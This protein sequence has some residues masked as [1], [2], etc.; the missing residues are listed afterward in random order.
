MPAAPDALI[1]VSFGGP[2]GPD[3]V[4]P[5]LENVTRGRNVP[6]ERLREVAA[7]Y[8]HFGGV[9]PLHRAVPRAR[10]GRCGRSS[11]G[12]GRTCPSTGATATGTRCSPTRSGADGG[13]RGARAPSPS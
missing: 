10:G 4:L 12:T 5:F 9:S 8:E 13:R 3:D 2:E 1:V 6:Q 7:H 11:R